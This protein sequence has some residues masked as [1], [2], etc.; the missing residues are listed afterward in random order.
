MQPPNSR[1]SFIKL[2]ENYVQFHFVRMAQTLN[3]GIKFEDFSSL[4]KAIKQ[5]HR[6]KMFNS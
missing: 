1:C 5:Y 3:I 2:Q 4:E 6:K